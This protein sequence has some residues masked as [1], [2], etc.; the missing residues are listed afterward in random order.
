MIVNEKFGVVKAGILLAILFIIDFYSI[1][2]DEIFAAH[3][4]MILLGYT[5]YFIL[6]C[7]E[8]M[9]KSRQ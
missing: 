1:K 4:F 7:N 9:K 3:L 5:V 2:I 6:K 8:L